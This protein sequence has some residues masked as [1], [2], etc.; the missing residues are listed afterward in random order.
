MYIQCGYPWFILSLY[1]FSSQHRYVE[2][3]LGCHMKALFGTM[4]CQT[5]LAFGDTHMDTT[6]TLPT[7]PSTVGLFT[8]LCTSLLPMPQCVYLQCLE[9]DNSRP[10][11]KVHSPSECS[12]PHCLP[13]HA[14]LPKLARDAS[15][16]KLHCTGDLLHLHR[17]IIL[18][19]TEGFR[20]VGR[21]CK[22]I[23]YQGI[24]LYK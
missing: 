6:S 21:N 13:H 16:Q 14:D 18:L 9:G 7:L 3:S 22:L 4:S 24:L 2:A 20:E 17:A 12:H 8:I 1:T 5:P 11:S 23:S 19:Q 15:Q 10:R